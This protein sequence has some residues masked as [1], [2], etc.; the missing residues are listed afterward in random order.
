MTT[1]QADST[2]AKRRA[3]F[4]ICT[5]LALQAAAVAARIDADGFP[6]VDYPMYS[7]AR[8][9][10]DRT[11]DHTVFATL[12]DGRRE[13]VTLTDVY[14]DDFQYLKWTSAILRHPRPPFQAGWPASHRVKE[15]L[16][17]RR[18][19]IDLVRA[20]VERYERRKGVSVVE[21]DVE[22]G[23]GIVT[24]NGLEMATEPLVLRKLPY[25]AALRELP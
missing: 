18:P 15:A 21:L 25:P 22:S 2:A 4:V 17:V 1:P 24:R 23:M 12:T 5:V 20:L 6:F 13:K 9:E 10:G 19:D 11:D 8:F 14:L 3:T 16:G 7:S